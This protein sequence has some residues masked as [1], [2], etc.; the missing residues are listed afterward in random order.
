MTLQNW[1]MFWDILKWNIE[2]TILDGGS[3]VGYL[4][5]QQWF[6]LY[7]WD[8]LA[9]TQLSHITPICLHDHF[10]YFCLTHN[11]LVVIGLC[12][13]TSS[14]FVGQ[15]DNCVKW[16]WL[17]GPWLRWVWFK[18]HYI[19]PVLEV[20]IACKGLWRWDIVIHLC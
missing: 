14:N 18:M 5:W 16:Y 3:I 20:W 12:F 10:M 13:Y 8:F 1:I 11:P 6:D 19:L 4:S 7:L 2:Q 9:K 15:D 17:F